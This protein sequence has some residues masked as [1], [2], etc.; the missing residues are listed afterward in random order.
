MKHCPKC[1]KDRIAPA[2]FCFK[3]GSELVEI[4]RCSCG[5]SLTTHNVYCDQCGKKVEGL[6]AV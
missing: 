3:D 2:N 5:G 6:H 4:L 1:G